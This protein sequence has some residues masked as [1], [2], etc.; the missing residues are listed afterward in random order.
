M[1]VDVKDA[2]LGAFHGADSLDLGGNLPKGR[3]DRTNSLS[4]RAFP[5]RRGKNIIDN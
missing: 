4:E 5:Y 2:G 3:D 1:I